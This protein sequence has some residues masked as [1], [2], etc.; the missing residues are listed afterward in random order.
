MPMEEPILK[1]KPS[2]NE[3]DV[4]RLKQVIVKQEFSKFSIAVCQFPAEI[5][6]LQ[7][8]EYIGDAGQP[9]NLLVGFSSEEDVS[10]QK[11]YLIFDGFTGDGFAPGGGL[12]L[13]LQHQRLSG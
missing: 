1:M 6:V 2:V 3:C 11:L 10:G 12:G 4:R 8:F 7:Q 5:V 13:Q 9:G